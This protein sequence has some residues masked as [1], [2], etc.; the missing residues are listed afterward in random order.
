MSRKNRKPLTE[1]VHEPEPETNDAGEDAGRVV[2]AEF[3]RVETDNGEAIP[4]PTLAYEHNP[5]WDGTV[6]TTTSFEVEDLRNQVADLEE[7]LK[8]SSTVSFLDRFG[9]KLFGLTPS[10]RYSM[11]DK[12]VQFLPWQE[13]LHN[14]IEQAYNRI[15]D[16]WWSTVGS[17]WDMI[18]SPL[19]P[20]MI[21]RHLPHYRWCISHSSGEIFL[22]G[23]TY[24]ADKA[25]EEAQTVMALLKGI[26]EVLHLRPSPALSHTVYFENG[27]KVIPEINQDPEDRYRWTS[28]GASPRVVSRS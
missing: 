11:W 9:A 25:T 5:A 17:F 7:K 14:N 23:T 2:S 6:Y 4:S 18:P 26:F 13:H 8:N 19:R 24:S 10:E 12:D 21:E 27:T 15:S 16:F 3:A 22:S 1:P 28:P 20:G